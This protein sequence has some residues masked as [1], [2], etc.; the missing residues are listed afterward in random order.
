MTGGSRSNGCFTLIHLSISQLS[1]I[2]LISLCVRRNGIKLYEKVLDVQDSM[3]QTQ[4]S[5]HQRLDEVARIE[6]ENLTAQ[7][8]TQNEIRMLAKNLPDN[9]KTTMDK[10]DQLESTLASISMGEPHLRSTT[11]LEASTPEI[12]MKILRAELQRV[13]KPTVEESLDSYKSNHEVQLEGIRRNL[14]QIILD[15]GRSSQDQDVSNHSKGSQESI[16]I[17]EK[18]DTQDDDFLPRETTIENMD[19]ICSG[20]SLEA[21]SNRGVGGS[22]NRS[23]SRSWIFR[24]PIGVLIVTVSASQSRSRL[25]RRS[26]EAFK[27]MKPSSARH[28]YRVSLDFQPAPSLWVRRGLSMVCKSQQD[29]RGCYQICPMIS[30]F[31][32]VS[33]DAEVFQCVIK[34]DIPGLQYLFE[35]RLAA[36]TDRTP[37]HVSLLHVSAFRMSNLINSLTVPVCLKVRPWGGVSIPP[38][39]RS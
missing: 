22:W 24:W 8:S 6:S 38:Q 27:I 33:K 37:N 35:A 14:D 3:Q 17:S 4:S 20:I 19:P 39:R 7:T 21:Q 1:H 30:T 11:T 12:F 26:Y 32:I 18:C 34:G 25:R 36:P 15:L 16:T 23:W 9:H 29:Q 31:A 10:L 28:N 2:S 13:V 5:I